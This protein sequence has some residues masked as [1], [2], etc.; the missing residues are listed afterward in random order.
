ME[1]PGFPGQAQ[2][3][4]SGGL[5]NP[6]SQIPILWSQISNASTNPA[7]NPNCEEFSGIESYVAEKASRQDHTFFPVEMSM[8]MQVQAGRVPEKSEGDTAVDLQKEM[9]KK[10][11]AIAYANAFYTTEMPA[12]FDSRLAKL[13]AAMGQLKGLV[14]KL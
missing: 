5:P 2:A 8:A 11:D 3:R 1:L 9:A 4:E 6:K 12:E 13:E 7:P 10:L 14:E